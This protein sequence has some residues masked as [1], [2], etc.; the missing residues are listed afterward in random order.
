[1]VSRAIL[2]GWPL[3]AGGIGRV[4]IVTPAPTPTPT[5]TPVDPPAFAMAARYPTANNMWADTVGGTLAADGASVAMVGDVS[6]NARHLT[7]FNCVRQGDALYFN[8]TS[9]YATADAVGAL[10]SGTG[11]PGSVVAA[12]E[13]DAEALGT[14]RTIF[15]YGRSSAAQPGVYLQAA[16]SRW[17][18]RRRGNGGGSFLDA[19]AGVQTVGALD[20]FIVSHTGTTSTIQKNRFCQQVDAAQNS[21]ATTLDRFTVGAQRTNG[22]PSNYFKGKVREIIVTTAA[23]SLVEQRDAGRY[24]RERYIGTSAAARKIA[25]TFVTWGQSNASGR[26]TAGAYALNAPAVVAGTA[27]EVDYDTTTV[28]NLPLGNPVGKDG[29]STNTGGAWPQF[30]KRWVEQ[31]PDEVAFVL[32]TSQGATSLQPSTTSASGNW[33]VL[34]RPAGVPEY[35]ADRITVRG[36]QLYD[37]MMASEG[38]D[39]PDAGLR[40]EGHQGENDAGPSF[41]NTTNNFNIEGVFSRGGYTAGMIALRDYCN[42]VVPIKSFDIAELGAHD[43]FGPNDEP[44]MA[45]I[46]AAQADAVAV[47]PN[48]LIASNI[49]KNFGAGATRSMTDSVHYGMGAVDQSA[50]GYNGMGRKMAETRVAALA[51]ETANPIG[52][53]ISLWLVLPL[54]ASGGMAKFLVQRS[55]STTGT[56]SVN[57]A[58]TGAVTTSGT[59]SFADGERVKLLSFA[60]SGTNGATFT[61]TLSGPVNGTLTAFASQ[62]ATIGAATVTLG[63]LA[64]DNASA[65]ANT[66]WTS[67]IVGRTDGSTITA[68]SNDGTTLTVSGDN[69]SGT[70][71]T[72]GDKQVTLTETLAG[73]TNSGRQ[74]TAAV[75]VK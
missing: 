72:V 29:K 75:S 52:A 50:I 19:V 47:I 13:P 71:T 31:R 59:I 60:V 45:L 33:D 69:V 16:S 18:Y 4:P 28:G 24:V 21:G 7:C 62:T 65:T 30:V 61:V 8:G 3:G 20:Y 15:S 70:F 66:P 17:L 67:A 39:Y 38:Y 23:L 5:P 36:K 58:V 48:G 57:Y 46:R 43:G 32:A 25:R 68:T 44:D 22:A 54:V 49:Q 6:G 41:N 53:R 9:A 64:L 27:F 56:A 10:A 55:N 1:M 73:A 35:L 14:T 26:A 63:P 37:K 12:V 11:V 74:S 51:T 40:L 34:Y 42:A 2:N